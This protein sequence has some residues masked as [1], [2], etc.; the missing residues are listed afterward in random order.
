[1]HF[2]AERKRGY[3]ITEEDVTGHPG[4]ESLGP[5][6]YA[7]RRIAESVLN[8]SDAEHPFKQ[9]ADKATELIREALYDY[10][11]THMLSDLEVNFQG[12]L[13]RL[14]DDTVSAILS[15]TPNHRVTREKY[16]AAM[17]SLRGKR[18]FI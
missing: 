14:V 5:A 6:Y 8:N 18:C 9:A 1:R 13:Y 11:E 3:M 16:K 7:A 12:H 17:I 2:T 10:V 4:F 15:Q